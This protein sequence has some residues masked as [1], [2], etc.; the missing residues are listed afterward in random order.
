M[1]VTVL[2]VGDQDILT[3]PWRARELADAIPGVK[4]Q[5]LEGGGHGFAFEIPD[6]LNQ[7]VIEFLK[8][9]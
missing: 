7:A 5:T 6:R 4:L 9:G 2:L 1:I 3:P 8:D